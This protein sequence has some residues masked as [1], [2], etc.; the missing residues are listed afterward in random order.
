MSAEPVRSGRPP[1][2]FPCCQNFEK[3][4]AFLC[5]V[6]LIREK[7]RRGERTIRVSHLG[8]FCDIATA[9]VCKQ[10]VTTMFLVLLGAA[11]AVVYLAYKY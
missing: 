4:V 6:T 5:N 3:A 2:G 11:A 8:L 1:T 7:S 9:D 10:G